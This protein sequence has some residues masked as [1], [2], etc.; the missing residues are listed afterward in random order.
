MKKENHLLKKFNELR[1]NT[2]KEKDQIRTKD[3]KQA[4]INLTNE[5]LID[6]QT[7]PIKFTSL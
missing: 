4:F 5:K 7:I 6:L 2:S 3:M 1:E